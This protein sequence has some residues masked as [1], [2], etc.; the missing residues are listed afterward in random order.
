M[1]LAQLYIL[2]S[3][4][5]FAQ[6]LRTHSRMQLGLLGGLTGNACNGTPITHDA[7]ALFAVVHFDSVVLA[8]SLATCTMK[9]HSKVC[10]PS[11]EFFISDK[12][13]EIQIGLCNFFRISISIA[14]VRHL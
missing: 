11:L 4:A 10:L 13:S 3:G 7:G 5:F 14:I 12:L 2:G 1:Y 9:R 8:G 6:L